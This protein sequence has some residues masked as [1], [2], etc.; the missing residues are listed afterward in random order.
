[1]FVVLWIFMGIQTNHVCNPSRINFQ[2]TSSIDPGQYL[3]AAITTI[4]W[5]SELLI[6]FEVC[7]SD[8]ASAL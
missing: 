7:D 6:I 1:M 5:W 3:F 8:P 2:K 4:C